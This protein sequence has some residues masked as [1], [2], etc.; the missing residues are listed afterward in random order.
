MKDI[1]QKQAASSPSSNTQK[2]LGVHPKIKA[3]AQTAL[4]FL[5]LNGCVVLGAA[6]AWAEANAA[7]TPRPLCEEGRAVLA[8]RLAYLEARL[9]PAPDQQQAWEAF[10]TAVR[11]AVEPL[12]ALCAEGLAPGA[13]A[14]PDRL[15]RMEKSAAALQKMFAGLRSAIAGIDPVLTSAQR[16]LLARHILPPPPPFMPPFPVMPPPGGMF[17]LPPPPF[18][19]TAVS[20]GKEPLVPQPF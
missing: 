15:E 9:S 11:A 12:D 1:P 17:G 7:Q 13:S 19:M 8:G 14:D 6:T 5:A 10:K 18:A 20:C 2:E 16:D 3:A 4:C